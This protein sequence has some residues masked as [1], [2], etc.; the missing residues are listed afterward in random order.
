MYMAVVKPLKVEEKFLFALC[1]NIE[2]LRLSKKYKNMSDL[3]GDLGLDPRIGEIAE[4]KAKLTKE[5][6]KII[7]KKKLTHQEVSDL[8]SVP[9]S[10]ITGIVSGSLQKVTIDRL[11]RIISSLGK[12]ISIKVKDAA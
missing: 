11:L 8:S 9:R 12:S 1:R 4:L 3:A 7:N 10:A 6:I 5:I 2:E